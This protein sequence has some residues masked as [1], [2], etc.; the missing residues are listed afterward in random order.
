MKIGLIGLKKSGKT[1]IFNALTRSQATVDTF[2]GRRAEPNQATVEVADARVEHLVQMYQ[3]R[4]TTR[5]TVEFVDFVGLSASEEKGEVFSASDL[6]LIKTMDALA[7]V[8]RGFE[9][10]VISF[11]LS[12][13]SRI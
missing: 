10:P 8:L 11:Q 2:E 6:G 7:L 12:W 3:P 13:C 4:K 9:H 1:T 5:A